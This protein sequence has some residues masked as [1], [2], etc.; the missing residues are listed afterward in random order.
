MDM[1]FDPV[2]FF[3][4]TADAHLTVG[5]HEDPWAAAS[6]VFNKAYRYG[7]PMEEYALKTLKQARQARGPERKEKLGFLAQ[8]E[9]VDRVI[10]RE[11][12][13]ANAS[14]RKVLEGARRAHRA[15]CI[16]SRFRRGRSPAVDRGGV[17]PFEPRVG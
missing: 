8:Y 14:E 12:G 6:A 17:W 11:I 1:T 2:A 13:D 4:E 10:S 5:P 7:M 15:N 9:I 3:A 16:P